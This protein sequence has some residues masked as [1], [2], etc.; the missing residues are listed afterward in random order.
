[1]RNEDI[2]AGGKQLLYLDAWH[3]IYG[4]LLSFTR[5]AH[6][7]LVKGIVIGSEAVEC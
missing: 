7:R 6:L 3:M 1:M 2:A 5:E 4:A